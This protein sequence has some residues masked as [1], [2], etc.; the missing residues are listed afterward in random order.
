MRNQKKYKFFI[1]RSV[2]GDAVPEGNFLFILLQLHETEQLKA[3]GDASP[4]IIRMI[5]SRRVWAGR[6]ARMGEMRG[7]YEVL[8]GIPKGK[9]PLGRR[10]CRWEGNI[11]MVIRE[12][13][14]EYVDC[15]YLA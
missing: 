7:A 4:S 1:N 15:I 10:R 6:V 12:V 9:R 14:W 2:K 11:G 3:A 8:V 13:G 5:N